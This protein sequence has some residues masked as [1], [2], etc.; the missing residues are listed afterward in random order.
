MILRLKKLE[1]SGFKSFAK[2][3]HFD[4]ARPITAIVGPNGSGKSN[5]A[6]SLRW[7]LGEQSLK[8]IRGKKGEDLIFNGSQSAPRMGKASVALYFDNSKKQ[9]PVE[10]GEV[11]ISR[12]VYRDGKNEYLLNGSEVRLKDIVELLSNVGLGVSQHHIIGQGEADRVLYSSPKERQ[13]AIE[14]AL[15]LKI[16]QFKRQ[17]A[18]RKLARTEENMRQAQALQKEIGP[19]LKHLERMVEKFNQASA[20]KSDLEKL[21]NVYLSRSKASLEAM[22]AG[23]AS[24]KEQPLKEIGDV[25]KKIG[26]LKNKLAELEKIEKEPGEAKEFD[27]KLASLRERKIK[28]ERD[29]GRLEGMLEAAES[30]ESS[31]GEEKISR[32]E[33]EALL[34]DIDNSLTSAMD[35]DVLEEVRAIIQEVVSQIS[36]FVAGASSSEEAKSPKTNLREKK[37]NLEEELARLTGEEKMLAQK[38]EQSKSSFYESLRAQRMFANELFELEA[39]ANDLRNTVR[40]FDIEREKIKL[41]EEEFVKETEEAKRHLGEDKVK[42]AQAEALSEPEREKAKKEIDRLK[43]RLEEA[44]GVDPAIVKEYEEIKNRDEFFTKE[45]DDLIKAAK[46]LRQ[47]SRELAEKIEQDFSGGIEKIN[48]EFQK[49]FETMF[50]GGKARLAVIRP[51][52]H[53]KTSDEESESEMA[54]GLP[55]E[56]LAK[57]GGVDIDVNLPRKKIKGLDMLSGGERAL[58]SIALLFAMSA[59]NPPPFLVLD[60]TDAALDESNSRRYGEMLKS[61]SVT[62]QIITIT[63]NRETMKQAGVLYGVTMGSDGVSRMLSLKF[64]EAEEIAQ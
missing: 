59:V 1:L 16:Y 32:E 46:G 28:I 35:T 25:E 14:D 55:A 42:L 7:V 44:G 47:I 30:A 29:L 41:R 19:H 57:E 64:S 49:F 45:L 27:L 11:V 50:G 36:S 54:E 23:L 12:R 40:T 17:E 34:A 39:K 13:S 43:F 61:L 37:K 3:A 8:S 48:K 4:F 53:A 38:Q 26:E 22:G 15:G 56:D 62:T 33:V 5:V 60:E 2:P 10:F 63:H 21:L 58:T 20:I 18:E 24:K 31:A 9:F 52:K 51:Q 6:E